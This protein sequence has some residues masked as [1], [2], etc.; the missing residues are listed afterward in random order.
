MVPL[1]IRNLFTKSRGSIAKTD[2]AS[3]IAP[4]QS[5]ALSDTFFLPTFNDKQTLKLWLSYV[6]Y[7][8]L[9]GIISQ[10]SYNT[11]ADTL[12]ANIIKTLI[13][14]TVIVTGEML[15]IANA[16][17]KFKALNWRSRQISQYL[18]TTVFVV[19]PILSLL[20]QILLNIILKTP[21]HLEPI[22]LDILVNTLLTF[23]T[24]AILLIYFNLQ[25]QHIRRVE[26]INQQ[27][28]I[29]QNEQLKARITPHFFFNLLNTMQYLI[30]SDPYEAEVMVRHVSTLYRVSFDETR[31]IALMDE[32]ELCESYLSIEKYRFDSKLKVTWQLPDADLLYDMVITSLTLQIVIEKMIVLVVE[33]TTEPI[34]IDIAITWQNDVAKIDILTRLSPTIY[35]QIHKAIRTKLSFGSQI[36]ILR[37]YY[38]DKATIVYYIDEHALDVT[39]QYPLKDVGQQQNTRFS[40]L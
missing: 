35:Q 33:M 13:N 26:S 17:K 25:Y 37:Q 2:G 31:E 11:D 6:V 19:V 1:K 30:E 24:I 10:L 16:V 15:F 38:G 39:I 20:V 22:L 14:C 27:R 7:F 40:P 34:C 3:Q 23:S 32:I 8:S 9:F 36:D 21:F 29:E 12:I 28:L 18:L 5:N 4:S